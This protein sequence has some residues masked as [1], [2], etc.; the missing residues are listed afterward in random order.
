MADVSQPR[1]LTAAEL[2]PQLDSAQFG[3]ATTDELTPLDEIIGQPRAE[4]AFEIGVGVRQVGYHIFVSGISGT[5]RMELARRVLTARAESEPIAQDWVYVNNFENSEEP[6][7]IAL[8]AGQGGQ[9][10]RDLTGL[11]SRLM[12]ELPKAFQREDFSQ[13]KDRLRKGY[14]EKGA[15]LFGELQKQAK[16]RDFAVQQVSDHQVIF[17]PLKD[18]EPISE[19]AAQK[20]APDEMER[21]ERS[22]R[23]LFEVLETMAQKQA[24]IERQ[25]STDVRQVERTFATRLIEPLLQEIAGRYRNDEVAQWLDRLKGHF[26]RNLDRFRKRADRL[27]DQMAAILGEVPQTDLQERFVEYQVNLVVDNSQERH[28]PVVFEPAPNYRNLFG[29]IERMV[30]RLGH[31]VSNF[32]R[33]RSGSLVRANGGYLVFDLEDALQEPFVWKQLKRALKTG[34]SR[35]EVYDPFEMF[36][37]ST[38]RPEPIPLDVKLVVLGHPLLYHLLYLYDDDFRELFKVKAEFDTEIPLGEETG[39][40]YGRLVNKLSSSEGIAPFDAA[41]VAVLIEAS[42]RLVGDRRRLTAEFRRIA[43]LIREAAY[44]ARKESATVVGAPHV[45]RALNEQTYRSDLLSE[46]IRELIAD[47][48]LNIRLGSPAVGSVHGL[49]VADLG[50][51]SAGW[52]V[53]LTASVGV[54]SAGV[55]NIER[56]SRLS[57]RTFDKGMLI[58]EGFLRNQYAREHP[59]ALSASLALEQTYGGV[60]GDSA[61]VAELLCLL[62]AIAGVP[63][64]QDIAITGSINQ[65]GEVQAIGAVTEKVEGFFDVCRALGLTGQQGVC[66]PASNVKHLLPRD[67]VLAAINRGEFHVWPIETIDQGIVLLTGMTAGSTADDS[68]FHGRVDRRL[69][70]M[71]AALKDYQPSSAG[72]AQRVAAAEPIVPQ[73]P[74]PPL[75]GRPESPETDRPKM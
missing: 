61:S 19:E 25:L 56:E 38:L 72:P 16:E 4:R 5:G 75:P 10:Q 42:A 20:L 35:I 68:T 17:M 7:A 73:D 6:Q 46:K 62:S 69:R 54:G 41:A 47:G 40:I 60:D 37:I 18:G 59:L 12:D 2:G 14:Q 29:T 52:P 65:L 26:I 11:I 32:T 48:T 66:I 13:E 22:Q 39:T 31:V 3:F 71:L 21:I 24:E 27:Q 58:L 30:D 63:L 1:S 28:A 33:I 53:R 55:I 23:E 15:E 45:R 50:D 44:W 51:Y 9:L 8:P 67:D 34:F 43:D 74:R 64:R 70:E 49:T 57:G 36:T